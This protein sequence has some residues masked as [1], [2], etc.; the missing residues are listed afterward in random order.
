MMAVSI[1]VTGNKLV[2]GSPQRLFHTRIS[3][4]GRDLQQG[5]QYDVAADGRFLINTE[6]SDDAPTPITLIQNWNPDAKR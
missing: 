6:L 5:R 2:P 1:S 3:R 4:G